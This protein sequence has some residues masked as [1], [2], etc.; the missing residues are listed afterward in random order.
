M[1]YGFFRSVRCDKR[2]EE[3]DR[4]FPIV[5]EPVFYGQKLDGD[6]VWRRLDNGRWT[7]WAKRDGK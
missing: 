1:R 7:G 3:L 5:G 4:E 2:T 6:I